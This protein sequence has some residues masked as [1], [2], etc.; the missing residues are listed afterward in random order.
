MR[1]FFSSGIPP[2]HKSTFTKSMVSESIIRMQVPLTA[3]VIFQSL[4]LIFYLFSDKE[5]FKV[6]PLYGSKLITIIACVVA[7]LVLSRVQV[8]GSF[9][10]RHGENVILAATGLVIFST[11]FN[12]FVAQ[13]ITS[14]ISIYI[15][16][17]FAAAS[18]VR[19]QP[20]KTIL[21]FS[22]S[23]LV[24]ALGMPVFQ[25]NPEYAL[26]HLMNGL[27]MTLLAFI[28]S[29]MFFN[30]SLND[31]L[32]KKYIQ[33]K[34]EAL[35]FLAKHDGLTTLYNHRTILEILED[36][37]AESLRD[38]TSLSVLMLD[39][40]HFKL[41]NDR[42]GHRAGDEFLM[43]CAKII[44]NNIR[45]TDFAG[46]YGGDEFIVILPLIARHHV[47]EISERILSD[48]K[49]KEIGGMHLTFCCGIADSTPLVPRTAIQLIEHADQA[50]YRGKQNGKNK[51]MI[52]EED[53]FE[54][55]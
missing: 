52:Y 26:S 11:I 48:L 19:I 38:G 5:S 8:K 22:V 32:D 50:L 33:E 4:Q 9:F 23:Y 43:H 37:L 40:D 53:S 39:L 35:E 47:Y 18:V 27:I 7:S 41:V 10:E 31:Y 21:L 44:Q 1:N 3:I 24:F 46:R 17:I 16:T 14:D 25:K 20:G 29:R 30:Y 54:Q 36:T 13:A 49:Q 51:I 28:I 42:L 45:K 2:E 6:L 15:L 55:T 34:N 12:T